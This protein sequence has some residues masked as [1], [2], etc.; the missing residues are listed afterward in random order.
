M[1]LRTAAASLTL[2]AAAI[3]L[4]SAA[5]PTDWP[6]FRGHDAA[7]MADQ[8]ALPTTWS[9]KDN[10][11]WTATIPGRG[12]SSPIVW[13]NRVYVTSAVSAGVFKE[14]STGIYGNDYAADLTAQGLSAAEV[15]KRVTARDIELTAEVD[16]V[17]YM[18]YAIDV[19]TGAIAWQR[20][21]HRGKPPGGRHR[22]NTYASETPATDGER[23]YV[24]IANAFQKSYTLTPSGETITWGAYSALDA[25]TG[26]VLWQTPDPAGSYPLGAVTVANGVVYAESIAAQGPLYAFDAAT[27]HLLWNFESHGSALGG[28]AVVNGTVYWGSGYTHL[29]FG[30][31]NNKLFAF[32]RNGK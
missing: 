31:G 10:I 16:D 30:G 17:K 3:S 25:A 12:W 18:I 29:G 5:G 24:A 21:A 11:A 15:M 9:A 23:I 26:R 19:K 14:P 4:A 6:Q 32:S 22:K 28:A 1:R 7:G 2:I 8:F 27:G 13:G 20:E